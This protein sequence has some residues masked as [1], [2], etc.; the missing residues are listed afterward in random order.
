[1]RVN[2]ENST[3]VYKEENDKLVKSDKFVKSV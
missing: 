2:A 3:K 1:M